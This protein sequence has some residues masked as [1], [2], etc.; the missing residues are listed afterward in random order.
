MVEGVRLESVCASNGTAGSNPVLSAIEKEHA[1]ACSFSMDKISA[2]IKGRSPRP[3]A[4]VR[5]W[6]KAGGLSLWELPQA[7]D[8]AGVQR[9]C[10]CGV[11]EHEF[12]RHGAP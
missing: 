1:F 10:A 2:S 7:H 8:V 9:W 3:A 4:D 5:V 12:V 11:E 6:V